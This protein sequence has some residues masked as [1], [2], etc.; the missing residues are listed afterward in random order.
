LE[1]GACL[2]VKNIGKP[3]A[4]KPHA[5]FDEGGQGETCSL[6]YPP[7]PCT[8]GD[9]ATKA[10]KAPK[11]PVILKNTKEVDQQPVNH[12]ERITQLQKELCQDCGPET[13]ECV[14]EDFYEFPNNG[15]EIKRLIVFSEP[16]GANAS[17][18]VMLSTKD[19]CTPV[20]EESG[21]SINFSPKPDKNQFPDIIVSSH[22][23]VEE[24]VDTGYHWDGKMYVA[25]GSVKKNSR[26]G[27]EEVMR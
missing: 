7:S 20:V 26:T 8:K 27:T 2:T 19:A 17:Y 3:C 9:E 4:G 16:G 18:T 10:Q 13:S 24:S 25:E 5:R 21:A 12:Q 23:S 22:W 11:A 14:V 15:I 6:L 1:E